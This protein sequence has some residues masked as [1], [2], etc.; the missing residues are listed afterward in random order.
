MPNVDISNINIS[1]ISHATEDDDKV[2]EAMIYFLPEDIEEDSVYI[3]T[4]ENEGCFGNP[5]KIH[6]ITINKG[7]VAKKVFKH[8]MELIKSKEKNV[9]KLKGD[10]DL[11]VEKSKIYLR[12]NKQ[13]AYLGECDLVDGDD[14]VRIVINFKIFSPKN[15]EEKVKEIVLKELE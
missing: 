12:F 9:N 8:I 10:I 14:T 2:L 15:K 1:A 7:K 13:K 6:T 4:V 3:E 5:I 11:R